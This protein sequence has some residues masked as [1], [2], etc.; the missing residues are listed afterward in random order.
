MGYSP[1][2]YKE[3]DMTEH[4]HTFSKVRE[5]NLTS[6]IIHHHFYVILVTQVRVVGDTQWCSSDPGL[7]EAS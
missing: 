3:S 2:S 7:R 4:T 5:S 1:R 6:E